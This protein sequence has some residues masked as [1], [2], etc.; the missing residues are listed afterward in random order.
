MVGVGSVTSGEK[1]EMNK[2]KDIVKLVDSK[3]NP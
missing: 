1:D 3:H 2:V